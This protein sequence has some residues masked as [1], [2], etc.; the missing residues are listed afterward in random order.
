MSH[1]KCF[2]VQKINDYLYRLS[3][4]SD[5]SLN[6]VLRLG[7]RLGPFYRNRRLNAVVTSQFDEIFRWL[8]LRHL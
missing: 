8:E 7:S 2:V 5:F 3:S 6:L 4:L 1:I